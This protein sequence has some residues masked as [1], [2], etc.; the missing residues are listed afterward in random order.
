MS[1][2]AS[3]A[4][5]AATGALAS[6][7]NVVAGGG[8]FLTLPVLIFLGL[9]PNVANA[10]NR[11]G[12]LLQ[13][14]AGVWGFHRARVMGWDSLL[15]AG[16]PATIGAAGGTWLALSVSDEGFRRLLSLLMVAVTLWTLL[17]RVEP[18]PDTERRASP[19]P[20]AGAFLLV[21][22]YGGFVQAGVGFFILAVTTHAGIDLI[23]GNAIKVLCVLV[24]TT[25]SLAI[26]AAYGRVDWPSGLALGAGSLI[27]GLLG[28]RLTV[29][30]GERWVRGVVTAA[31]V[32]F[33]IKL[34]FG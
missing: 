24:L 19:L 14:V 31:V 7:L 10:T 32:L 12:V 33:A 28:V 34:W 26:F 13:N 17:A 30:K 1:P 18:A 9:P 8:S 22:V 29:R 6:A 2:E 4:I 27:G 16:L 25:L 3:Y 20:M 23:R 5:L 21:G 11:V 15:W